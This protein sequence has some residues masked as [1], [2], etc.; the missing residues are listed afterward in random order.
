MRGTNA[1]E[2]QRKA[3]C[4]QRRNHKRQRR[5]PDAKEEN[6]TVKEKARK[7]GGERRIGQRRKPATKEEKVMRNRGKSQVGE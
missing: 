3:K 2:S 7:N 5:K 1:R 4:P 6:D